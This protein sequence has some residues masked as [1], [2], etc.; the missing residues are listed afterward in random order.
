LQII[1]AQVAPQMVN[2]FLEQN[3]SRQPGGQTLNNSQQQAGM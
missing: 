3:T 1:M 2:N